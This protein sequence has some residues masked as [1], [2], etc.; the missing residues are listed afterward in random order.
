MKT[1][2][3]TEQMTIVYNCDKTSYDNH[4]CYIKIVLKV[5]RNLT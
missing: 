4:E 2:M 1:I 3:K 5:K